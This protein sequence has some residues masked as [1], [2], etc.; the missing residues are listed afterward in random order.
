MNTELWV[1]LNQQVN[2]VWHDFQCDY[3][4]PIFLGY[5]F[6]DGSATFR[7]VSHEHRASVLWAEHDVVL[8]GVHDVVVRLVSYNHEHSIQ[9]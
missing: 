9:P 6:E 1:Y 8:A 7:Y 5:L 2:V 3:F 4:R